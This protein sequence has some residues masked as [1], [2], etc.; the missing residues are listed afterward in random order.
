[1]VDELIAAMLKQNPED[2]P[3]DT[4]VVMQKLLDINKRAKEGTLSKTKAET[5]AALVETV[6]I[7]SNKIGTLLRS[8]ADRLTVTGTQ[9]KRRKRKRKG[10]ESFFESTWFLL[11]CL[12]LIVGA[13]AYA[14]WPAGPDAMLEEAKKV[15]AADNTIDWQ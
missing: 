13:I 15:L 7:P 3:R 14:F 9:T 8:V 12:V 4:Y 2:R 1:E 5:E 6:E 11:G 10:E